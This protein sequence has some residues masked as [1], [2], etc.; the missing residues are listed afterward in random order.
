MP[1]RCF[2]ANARTNEMLDELQR[3][4][5]SDIQMVS[6]MCLSNEIGK[7]ALQTYAVSDS[8]GS[9]GSNKPHVQVLHFCFKVNMQESCNHILFYKS[10]HK[11]HECAV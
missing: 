3:T 1:F 8:G 9:S 6:S 4:M 11:L 7:G 5:Q 2:I 10:D